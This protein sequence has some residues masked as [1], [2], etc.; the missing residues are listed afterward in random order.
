MC[1][2]FCLMSVAMVAET[3]LVN[4]NGNQILQSMRNLENSAREIKTENTVDAS[5]TLTSTRSNRQVRP[6]ARQ[7]RRVNSSIFTI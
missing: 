1:V 3:D 5:Q 4:N 6:R 7:S 2:V